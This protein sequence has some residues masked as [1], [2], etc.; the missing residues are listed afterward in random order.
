[1]ILNRST[2]RI[3]RFFLDLRSVD[4]VIHDFRRIVQNVR[5][6]QIGFHQLKA[7]RKIEP[8]ADALVADDFVID[9][10]ALHDRA[11]V[12]ELVPLILCAEGEEDGDVMNMEPWN[13]L[14]SIS[15]FGSKPK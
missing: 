8:V 1:M 12:L 9:I 5:I 4:I 7:G 3:A 11:V 14:T 2:R 15:F 10:L 13:G 6:L